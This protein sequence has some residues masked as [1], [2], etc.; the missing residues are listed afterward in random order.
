MVQINKLP[1][2]SII[3]PV[4]KAESYLH[5][6]IDSILA[7]TFTDW[8]LL[9]I[10]DGSPDRS[11][12][13][14]DE[15]A[16]KD[17][18]IRVYHKKNGG[19]G[20]ARNLGLEKMHGDYVM[21]VDADDM[22]EADTL[23]ICMAQIESNDLDILQFSYT[24]DENSLGSNGDEYSETCCLFDYLEKRKFLVSVWSSV[25][26]SS[27]IRTYKVRF[28]EHMK[29]AEDQLFIFTCMEYAEKLMRI[30]NRLY[31]Y[32]DNPLSATNN[33]KT[34]DIIYSAERCI[35][36][37]KMH[38]LFAFRL[39]G[40]VLLYIEKLI[41]RGCYSAVSELLK[42]LNPSYVNRHPWPIVLMVK[43]EKKYHEL[44]IFLGFII[45]TIYARSK[46]V[47]SYLKRKLQYV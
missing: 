40:L 32:V 25:I 8:E 6:C 37:K 19:V 38:P 44:G 16:L 29:L 11:G 35:E 46:C 43:V 20:S 14:C 39:D 45:Y 28:N 27:I 12:Y 24:R 23:K 5:R 4:Y 7:Q 17:K 9:L 10:D 13:I 26:R 42:K 21:F 2:V 36:F 22:I 34:R 31:Y 30:P 33:E 1:K 41:L 15:Y 18:R 3:I 47:C